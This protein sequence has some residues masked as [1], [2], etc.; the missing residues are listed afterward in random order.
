MYNVFL[1]LP[2]GGRFEVDQRSGVVRTRGTEAFQLDMEYVLY[3]K[4]E[5]QNG[6]SGRKFQSTP[7]E[8]LS[9]VGGKRPPQFYMPSYEA[10]IREDQKKDSDIISVKAKSFADREIRYTLKAQGQG[11][12]TFNIGPS[13]GIVKLAKDL[14][15][16]DLRQPHIYQ[17]VVTATEDSGGFST[18]VELMIRVSDVNDNAPKFELPDYQA[19]NVDEDIPIG[20]SILK[21]KATDADSGNNAEIEYYVSNDHFAVNSK[22][23]ISNNRRLDADSNNAYYEFIVTAKD[24]G[25]PPRTGTATVR[26]YTENKNDEEPKFSQQVYTPNVDENAGPNTLVTTVVA[27]DKDGDG[28]TFGFVGGTTQSGLFRIEENTGVIRLV[29]GPINLDKDKYELNVTA[30]DD[31]KCCLENAKGPPKPS[32]LHTSTAVVVVFITD[33]NDNKPVFKD[34]SSYAPKIEEGAPN[35]SPVIKVAAY[36]KDKGVN[37]QVRYSIVQQPNQKGTKFNVDEETG[38]VFTNKVFDREGED[39]KFVSVTVKAVDSGEPSLEGVCSFTVEITDVNDNPPL[40][41]RQVRKSRLFTKWRLEVDN[42]ISSL[43]SGTWRT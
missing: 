34:C 30:M 13:S 9:I 4:A 43:F 21:V 32:S 5:D 33:V 39:G 41:D 42:L 38:E 6:R 36:D 28:V 35:G 24:R 8:R 23:V 10:E 7:E 20:S 2:A 40:F 12:G 26:V 37:G 25:D 31:G 11:A 29:S 14:D 19:H 15:F 3:V 1:P 17:L 16:E 27:S 22:G 18:H